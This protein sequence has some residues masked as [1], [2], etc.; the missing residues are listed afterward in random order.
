ML[1]GSLFLA[2]IA[3]SLS[4]SSA[5][6]SPRPKCTGHEET[7]ACSAAASAADPC[8][9]PRAGL[10]LFR[11]RFE[12]DTGDGGSWGISNVDIMEYVQSLGV[13]IL[14]SGATELSRRRRQTAS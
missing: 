3:L 10:W 2:L 11:Q 1:R 13:W 14:T 7:T 6:A 4:P 5:L 12:P 9:V 8:C